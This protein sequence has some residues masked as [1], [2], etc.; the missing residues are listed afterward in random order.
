MSNLYIGLISGTSIDAVDAALL[1]FDGPQ[2]SVLGTHAE[3][4]PQNLKSALHR[5]CEPRVSSNTS[6][7]ALDDQLDQIGHTDIEVGTLFA[8]AVNALLTTSGIAAS[9]ITAVGSHGQTIRHRPPTP[10]QHGFSL[11]IGDPYTIS[12]LTGI[13]TVADFRRSDMAL[14]GQGAPLAPLFHQAITP[15]EN[16][17][18]A[19]LNLGGI[20]NISHISNGELTAGFDTGPA[21]GLMDSWIRKTHNKAYDKN[22]EWAL[23][24]KTNPLLLS[25]LKSD[26]YFLLPA[27]K[28][29]GR[30]LFNLDWIEQ[31]LATPR[32]SALN[33]AAA[34]VQATLLDLT[35]ETIIQSSQQLLPAPTTVYACGGGVHNVGLMQRL[36]LAYHSIG[37]TLE[38]TN[39]LGI[40]AD[41]VEA[42]LF[43]WLAK[44]RIEERKL[45]IKSVTGASRDHI[46][47]SIFTV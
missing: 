3:P 44:Q 28:S 30:E 20:A 5:L 31:H 7:Y 12:N 37:I 43:A 17:S 34:D 11:Q 22:G 8:K 46:A 47:G 38:T 15:K 29:T 6:K 4:I 14:G 13:T 19:F 26:A 9:D 35:V 32:I 2:F 23:N 18:C 41:F 36:Q 33:L 40:D 27:P 10:S 25:H 45:K 39:C 1:D 21:N 42:A 16:T 24:G